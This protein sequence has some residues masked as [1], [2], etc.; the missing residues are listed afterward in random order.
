MPEKS[1]RTRYVLM[2]AIAALILAFPAAMSWQ[3]MDSGGSARNGDLRPPEDLDTRMAK[4]EQKISGFGGAFLDGDGVLNVYRTPETNE[5]NTPSEIASILE[6]EIGEDRTRNGVRIV[7]GKYTFSELLEYKLNLRSLFG[8][9]LGITMLDVDESKNRIVVGVENATRITEVSSRVS[10]MNIPADAIE[11]IET[12]RVALDSHNSYYR[13]VK[14]G[15][16][17]EFGAFQTC[18]IGFIAD[19]GTHGRVVIT[20][21]HCG[22]PGNTYYQDIY[23]WHPIGT[24]ISGTDPSGPRYS[25][26][27]LHS[28]TVSSS[29]GQVH[30]HSDAITFNSASPKQYTPM[31]GDAVIKSGR[32]THDTLGGITNTCADTS[33]G[34]YGTLYC[35]VY[36]NYNSAGGDSGGTVYGNSLQGYKLYGIHW[37]QFTGSNI[38][39]LSPIWNIEQD[40][41]TLSVR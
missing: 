27:I 17:E 9:G 21:G 37:G 11:V 2:A 14:G 8:E 4:I 15:I 7:E 23:P 22:D 34:T 28:L 1:T 24:G 5:D 30:H 18:S 13:P 6:N 31:Y 20:A 3:Q 39:V 41:G 35:Q 10:Q 29:K 36:A 33:H 12:G 40:Q 19:H 32:S 25:D 26:S 38:R 16:Q